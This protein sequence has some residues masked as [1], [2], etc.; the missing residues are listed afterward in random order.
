MGIKEIANKA[1]VSVTTVSLALNGRKGVSERT[2]KKIKELAHEEGYR[3]PSERVISTADSGIILFA[4]ISRDNKI[5]NKD[6]YHF[7]LEYINGIQSELASTSYTF[8]MMNDDVE[9]LPIFINKVNRKHVKG[10]IILGTE[11]HAEDIK[12]LDS[13]HSPFVIV[14]TYFNTVK[15]HFISMNNVQGV[16]ELVEYCSKLGHKSFN[17]VTSSST[18]GNIDMRER[19][20]RLALDSFSIPFK[21]PFITVE[22]GFEGAFNDMNRYL[23]SKPALPSVL[24]CFNDVAAYGVI[25]ALKIH[26]FRVPQDI[27]VVGF[28]D[29][30]MATMMEPHLS[31]VKV[32]NHLIGKKATSALI[33]IIL[34]GKLEGYITSLITTNFIMRDSILDKR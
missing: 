23:E 24:F 27:S 21:G 30:S 7:I 31:T 11:L 5:L 3:I 26:N 28:D 1:N 10:I 8:E 2:R 33:D 14:D 16:F 12:A 15:A 20:F 6:Q 4:Q 34:N 17:M 13:L 29:I 25:K 18:T 9:N 22:P 19:G 32:A